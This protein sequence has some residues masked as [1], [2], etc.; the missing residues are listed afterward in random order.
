MVAEIMEKEN[1][2]NKESYESECRAHMIGIK[3]HDLLCIEKKIAE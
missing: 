1:Q 2:T 3:K